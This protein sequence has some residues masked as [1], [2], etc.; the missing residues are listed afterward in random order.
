MSVSIS[1]RSVMLVGCFSWE[2]FFIRFHAFSIGFEFGALGLAIPKLVSPC[3]PG[4]FSQV[5]TSGRI[6]IMHEVVALMDVP[7]GK[8]MLLQNLQ[9]SRTSQ[10]N[11]L[12]EEEKTPSTVIS[13]ESTPYHYT[14][15][16]VQRI[17]RGFRVIS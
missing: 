6:T 1:F 4:S 2:M 5:W 8:N 17:D 7:N 3:P 11:V 9:T 10:G 15:R 13:T 12:G 14:V 16:V